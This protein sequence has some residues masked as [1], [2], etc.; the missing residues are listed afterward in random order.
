[1]WTGRPPLLVGLL[2]YSTRSSNKW[3]KAAQQQ[4]A[5]VCW[6]GA[7]C[8]CIL[9]LGHF[10]ILLIHTKDNAWRRI[11]L[12]FFFTCINERKSKIPD[13]VQRARILI[14]CVFSVWRAKGR[15]AWTLKRSTVSLIIN[16]SHC[17]PC[18]HMC[19]STPGHHL[20]SLFPSRAPQR[21]P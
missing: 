5:G 13:H 17:F 3:D 18:T 11:S 4:H 6:G 12:F 8:L 16:Y 20:C 21:H 15:V 14:D 19:K 2:G 9:F 1:M 7:L 10:R